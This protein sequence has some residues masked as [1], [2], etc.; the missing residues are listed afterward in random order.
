MTVP[1]LLSRAFSSG[2]LDQK[3]PI[4]KTC[5]CNK[6]IFFSFKH[7]KFLAKKFDIFLIFASKHRLWVHVRTALA[8]RF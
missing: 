8:R 1:R 3:S 2:L 4:M 7:R 6:Q 5:P